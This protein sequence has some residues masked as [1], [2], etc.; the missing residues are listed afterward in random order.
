LLST[1]SIGIDSLCDATWR[2][3]AAGQADFVSPDA[4]TL[5]IT[6]SDKSIINYQS[7]SISEAQSVQF[8]QPT[9]KATVLNRVMSQDPSQILGKLSSNGRVFLINP[10]GICFGPK[11]VIN[12]GSFLASTLN[13]LD[14]D[15]INDNFRFF[16]QEGLEK[17][18]IVNEGMISSSLDGFIALFA[19]GISNLGTIRAS[20][21][22]VVLAAAEKVIL[23]F[24][25]DGLIQFSV[26][27]DLKEALIENFGHIE[28]A[29]GTV[30]LSLHTAK[31]AIKMVVNTDGITPANAM[32]EVNG[33]IHLVSQSSITA[34]KV[35][36]DGGDHSRVEVEGAIN[37]STVASD[38]KGGVIHVLGDLVTL[39]GAQIQASGDA[40]G[41]EVLIAGAIRARECP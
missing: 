33:V 26:D 9:A 11:A 16:Q 19:S 14:E 22:K 20:A 6:A 3:V 38:E 5:Q 18:E 35:I 24:S 30:E 23:D 8:I 10:N 27:G 7:F 2:K 13:I 29:N 39:Q 36:L 15:F 40:G 41:G 4:H 1:P 32:E 21:G 28:S 25:G 12:T 17:A 31:D 34:K 37:A